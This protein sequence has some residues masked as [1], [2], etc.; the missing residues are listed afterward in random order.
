MRCLKT[1][2]WSLAKLFS[3]SPKILHWYHIS[4]SS[5]L[6]VFLTLWPV[7]IYPTYGRNS[8]TYGFWDLST[9]SISSKSSKISDSSCDVVTTG[10]SM[11]NSVLKDLGSVIYQ[12]CCWELSLLTDNIDS[13]KIDS[14][15]FV[16]RW[17][18][19]SSLIWGINS[20]S[21]VVTYS[22]VSFW[23][24]LSVSHIFSWHLRALFELVSL[25]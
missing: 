6:N 22:C 25:V 12:F 11:S 20:F 21:S 19:V 2:Y 9:T 7:H 10:S 13:S 17:E 16:A 18:T 8:V 15:G 5:K 1:C 4:A 23:I 24:L 3:L 14:S